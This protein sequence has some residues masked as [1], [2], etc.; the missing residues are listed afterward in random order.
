MRTAA[1]SPMPP[2]STHVVS[3]YNDSSTPRT[4]KPPSETSADGGTSCGGCCT[5]GTSATAV[6]DASGLAA[7]PMQAAVMESKKAWTT[8]HVLAGTQ[9][10]VVSG[11]M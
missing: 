1:H 6:T 7:R 11:R 3:S 8:L 5:A 10:E 9:Y 4:S 2:G